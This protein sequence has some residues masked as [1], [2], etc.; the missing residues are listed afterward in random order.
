MTI[1]LVLAPN[2]GPFTGPGTNTW[3]V[4]S[5]GEAIVIDPGPRIAS[6]E[7]AIEA[8]VAGLAPIAVLITHTHPDHAPA[9]NPLAARLGVPAI[10]FDAG[11]E[12]RPDRRIA[13]G[14][15]VTFGASSARCVATP[16]HT[17]DSVSYLVDDTV[18]VG[19]HVMGGSTVV[20]ED[21]AAYLES[22]DRLR[23]I[24]L[25][26]IHPGHGPVITDPDGLL[27]EYIDH[28]L[29]RERQILRALEDGAGSV[30]A[31]VRDVYREVDP[32]LHPAAAM[33]VAAHLLKLA[34]EGRVDVEPDP[35][36]DSPV[37]LR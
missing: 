14:E 30:G 2:P 19:D 33:S 26:T 8:A 7:A 34:G 20:V 25:A 28:R 22:L 1:D 4:S 24:G 17:P 18:F 31:I 35:A 36:W 3:V 6:H 11:P 12:F 37:V 23:G 13:D 15:V 5:Q 32:L 9:A 29:D 16:G 27:T 21:M 10:G